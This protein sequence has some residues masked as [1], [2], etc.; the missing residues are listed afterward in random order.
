TMVIDTPRVGVIFPSRQFRG[1]T[2]S[3]RA[4]QVGS[5][6]SHAASHGPHPHG[7]DVWLHAILRRVSL[8]SRSSPAPAS[9]PRVAGATEPRR[10]ARLLLHQP[11]MCTIAALSTGAALFF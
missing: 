6:E 3:P 11:N 4:S 7:G 9:S 5:R 1:G 8:S 10:L 2:H